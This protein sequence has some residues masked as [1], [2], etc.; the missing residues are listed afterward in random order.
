MIIK[1]DHCKTVYD[2]DEKRLK[3][4]SSKV[5]CVHCQKV[6]TIWPE[7]VEKK[8]RQTKARQE[9]L[10]VSKKPF[11]DQTIPPSSSDE[12]ARPKETNYLPFRTKLVLFAG[13]LILIIA[14]FVL[15]VEFQRP[16]SVLNRL[17]TNGRNLV[18]GAQAAFSADDLVRMNRFALHIRQTPYTGSKENSDFYATLAFNILT[19]GNML[20]E[21][22]I[23]EKAKQNQMEIPGGFE[24]PGLLLAQHYWEVQFEKFPGILA[25]FRKYKPILIRAKENAREAGFNI[26]ALM[27][28]LDSG[29]KKGIFKNRILYILDSSHWWY[30]TPHIGS[31]YTVGE[32]QEFWR[33]QALSGK[34]GFGNNPIH[35]PG[36]LYFPRFDEDEWGAWFSVWK[37]VPADG[38]FNMFSIDFDAQIVKK[39]LWIVAGIVFGVSVI[40]LVLIFVIAGFLGS[41]VTRPITELTRGSQEVAKGNYEYVVPVLQDDEFGEFTRQF[42]QMTRGQKERLNLMRTLEKLLSR[43]LAEKAAQSGLVLGGRKVDCSVMFTDFAGFSTITQ[44]K[45]AVETVNILNTY[46][47]GLVPIIKAYGGFPDKFI[48]D[49]IVALFGAPI[50]F[51]DHAER[52]LACAIEMQWKMREIN[53]KRMQEGKTVF[54]MRIGIN[55]GEVIAGAIGCDLKLEYTSIGETTNLANRMESICDIGHVRIAEDT[56]LR[57][58]NLFFQ[59]AHISETPENMPVKG[60]QKRVP[61]YRVF[62]DDFVIEKNPDTPTPSRNFYTYQK[63]DHRIKHDAKEVPDRS[64]NRHARYLYLEKKEK[65]EQ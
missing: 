36:N 5:R 48:G 10:P 34:G 1:C 27:I 46:F 56:F 18:A 7:E 31:A 40:L 24:Y 16:F 6:F 39:T 35:D 61:T 37:T 17:I 13:S 62:V 19:E 43:E 59:N 9:S 11:P 28:M 12:A 65:Q 33:E 22:D 4:K 52:A 26:T 58:R 49:A 15:P 60:Y 29:E 44:K 45:P 20:S 8:V 51:E 21:E 57:I 53:E 55:S 54:E 32:D 30:M 3:G 25:L 41:L 47:E 63:T 42:N 50:A 38:L 64:F 23:L 2:I 14:V